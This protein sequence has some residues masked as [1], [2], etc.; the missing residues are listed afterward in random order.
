MKYELAGR[1]SVGGRAASYETRD[2]EFGCTRI[3][4]LRN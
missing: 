1:R 2:A 4:S 3:G